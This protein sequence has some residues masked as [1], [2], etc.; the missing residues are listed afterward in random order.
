MLF[1]SSSVSLDSDSGN[2]WWFHSEFTYPSDSEDGIAGVQTGHSGISSHGAP[3]NLSKNTVQWVPF[4]PLDVVHLEHC[5]RE[6][7]SLGEGEKCSGNEAGNVTLT[8]LK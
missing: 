8:F 2:V 6:Y 3:V 5:Y 1:E 7:V 4:G